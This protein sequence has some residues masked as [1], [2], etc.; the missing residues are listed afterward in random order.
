MREF[1]L[2]RA[3]AGPG[4]SAEDFEDQ[5][6]AI[7]DLGP[8]R[9]FQVALLHGGQRAI[10]EH[11]RNLF[12]FDA[13]GDL[14]DLAFSEVGGGPDLA[15]DDDRLLDHVEIDRPSEP[16]RFGDA[17]L[18]GPGVGLLIGTAHARI[19]VG[20]EDDGASRGRAF[21]LE[22]VLVFGFAQ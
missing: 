13:L 3:L 8:K 11:E 20:S 17:R 12:V 18:G 4:A 7:D 2:Q 21:R 9:F 19:E 10:H 16:R 22:L 15:K 5:A 14:V 6:G 1:D